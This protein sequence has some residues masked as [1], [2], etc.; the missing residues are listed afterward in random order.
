MVKR[1]TGFPYN[2]TG[3]GKGFTYSSWDVCLDS[4]LQPCAAQYN[5]PP[6]LLLKSVSH[7][8]HNN[9]QGK[10]N[11]AVEDATWAQRG[12]QYSSNRSLTSA[13]DRGEW[14]TPR[15]G[16]CTAWKDLV[17]TV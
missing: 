4:D 5:L 6:P 10:V 12:V 2:S 11:F 14:S 1:V 7:D 15:S 16:R 8:V 13:L 17:P 9:L 3:L